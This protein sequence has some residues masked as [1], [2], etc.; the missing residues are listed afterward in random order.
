[1]ITGL[2]SDCGP[3]F[4]GQNHQ[5][6][7]GLIPEDVLQNGRHIRIHLPCNNDNAHF[8]AWGG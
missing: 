5:L 6:T 7:H 2:S 1:M 3:G 8:D 4:Q